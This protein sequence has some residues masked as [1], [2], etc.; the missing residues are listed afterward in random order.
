MAA[1]PRLICIGAQKAG[2]TWLHAMLRSHPSFD[3]LPTKEIH[4][5]DTLY[6]KSLKEFNERRFKRAVRRVKK[7]EKAGEKVPPQA[8]WFAAQHGQTIDDAW[9]TNLFSNVKK[10][11]IGCDFTPSYSLLPDAGV[12]HLTKLCPNARILFLLR[13]PVERSFSQV[14]MRIEAK[15]MPRNAQAMMRFAK[16]GNNIKRS[17]YVEIIKRFSAQVPKERFKVMFYDDISIRPLHLLEEVCRFVDVPFA[18]AQFPKASKKIYVGT[19]MRMPPEVR[20]YLVSEHLPT[21]RALA[22]TYPT[23]KGWLEKYGG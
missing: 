21:I 18:A 2:T 19:E 9:Y 13:D 11:A 10:G 1:Q 6:V 4:Y 14:R 23:A 3:M 12:A 5:F 22:E 15:E 8:R 20:S 16:A 17:R 7:L